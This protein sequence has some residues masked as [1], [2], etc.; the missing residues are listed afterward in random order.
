MM[1]TPRD[2]TTRPAVVDVTAAMGEQ[3]R[4]RTIPL[5]LVRSEPEI[6]TAAAAADPYGD[7]TI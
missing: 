5:R 1:M 6:E 3:P 2:G 7:V 4:P